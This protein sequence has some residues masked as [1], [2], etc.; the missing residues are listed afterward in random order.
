MEETS[1]EGMWIHS[2]PVFVSRYCTCMRSRTLRRS[3]LI[4]PGGL[5]VVVDT[6]INL[7]KE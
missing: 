2:K 5:E 3:A 1:I 7:N 4:T 6:L